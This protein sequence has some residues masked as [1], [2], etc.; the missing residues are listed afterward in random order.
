MTPSHNDQASRT[1]CLVVAR[2]RDNRNLPAEARHILRHIARDAAEADAHAGGI[3]LGECPTFC[4]RNERQMQRM[5][6]SLGL[7][8]S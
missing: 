5:P 3:D 4:R 1:A 8:K 7:P 6:G 2:P